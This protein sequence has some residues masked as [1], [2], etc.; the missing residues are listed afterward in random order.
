MFCTMLTMSAWAAMQNDWSEA[1]MA[2][3]VSLNLLPLTCCSVI[4]RVGQMSQFF[5]EVSKVHSMFFGGEV[6]MAAIIS[7]FFSVRSW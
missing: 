2:A 6:Q 4:S 5:L 3:A 7:L 1:S